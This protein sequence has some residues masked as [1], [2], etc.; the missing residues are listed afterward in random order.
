MGFKNVV[1]H[2]YK[3]H[4]LFGFYRGYTTLLVFAVPN[5]TVNFGTF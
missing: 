1:K 5:S 4:G 2:I 3:K